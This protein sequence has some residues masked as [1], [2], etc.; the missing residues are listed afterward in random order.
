MIKNSDFK[1]A[2]WLP[3]PHLQTMWP[4]VM[5]R[6]PKI[7]TQHE[8]IELADGDFLE[9][10]WSGPETGP[11][12]IIL[13]GLGGN[14]ESHYAKPL[15]SQINKAGWR[16]AFMYFRGASNTPNRLPRFYHAGDTGDIQA[17]TDIIQTREPGTPI[18][19]IGISMGGNVLLKW[20]GETAQDNP[21]TASVA[22]CVPFELYKAANRF[23]KGF[24]KFYQWWLLRDLNRSV[25]AK[26]NKLSFTHNHR[27]D[28]SPKTFWEFDEKITAPLHGFES[29]QDYYKRA[30]SKPYLNNIARPT[31]IL[32]SADDPFMYPDIIPTAKDLSPQ[33]E[34]EISQT[35]GHVGFVS[36]KIPLR[37]KYWLDQ[38]VIGYLEEQRSKSDHK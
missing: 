6:T 10:H 30:S 37:P 7:L 17:L 8:R 14:I 25:T 26:F 22:I 34:L 32:H 35:G 2:W 29:A 11:I 18:F 5:R 12:V 20:L 16:A 33:V 15:I 9:V 21:L 23:R 36:G 1:P 31:L 38:R 27:R 24:A 3:G 4:T 19:A 28:P 13:H